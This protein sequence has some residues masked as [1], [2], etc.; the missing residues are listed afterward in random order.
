MVA[1]IVERLCWPSDCGS[2]LLAD[3]GFLINKVIAGRIAMT[4]IHFDCGKADSGRW[5]RWMDDLMS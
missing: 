3:F 2:E 1:W 4:C 5:I